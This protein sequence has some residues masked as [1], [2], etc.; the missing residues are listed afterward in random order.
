MTL[1]EYA[2][3]ALSSLFVIIDPIATGSGIQE[4]PTASSG[5]NPPGV[6]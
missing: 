3:L 6:A 1:L 4:N 5:T 2:L